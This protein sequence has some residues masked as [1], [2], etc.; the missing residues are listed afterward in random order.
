[1]ETTIEIKF[2]L[3]RSILLSLKEK[4]DDFI[5]ELLFNNAVAFYRKN[6]LSLG[7][8]AELAGYSRMDFIWKL[9][10][11]DEPIFD[12]ED[13][14]VAEMCENATYAFKIIKNGSLL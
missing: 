5:Q 7:K 9:K 14:L 13:N 10:E 12:Y 1:M 11:I 4:E 6:K 8:A 3:N 2:K